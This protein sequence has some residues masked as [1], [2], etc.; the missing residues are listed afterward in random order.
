MNKKIVKNKFEEASGIAKGKKRMVERKKNIAK[1]KEDAINFAKNQH[2][3]IT[4]SLKN[5]LTKSPSKKATQTLMNR[6]NKA[7]NPSLKLKPNDLKKSK[8]KQGKLPKI[9]KV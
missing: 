1:G 2:K 6:I 5:A 8:G 4:T 9:I 3:K 7:I